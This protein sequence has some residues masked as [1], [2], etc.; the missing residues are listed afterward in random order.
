MEW[1]HFFQSHI[2]DRGRQYFKQGLVKDLHEDEKH[3]RAIVWGSEEYHVTIDLEKKEILR[4]N[5][6]CPY[7]DEGKYCKHMA[8]VLFH[9]EDESTKDLVEKMDERAIRDFLAANLERDENLLNRFRR[10]V[11]GTIPPDMNQCKIKID[12]VFESHAGRNDFINYYNANSFVSEL[13]DIID[14]DVGSLLMNSKYEEAFAVTHYIFVETANQDMDDSDGGKMIL[15]D[16]CLEIWRE[17]LGRC[18]MEVKRNLFHWFIDHLDGTVIDY[19]ESYIEGILFEDFKEDEFLDY[20]RKLAERKVNIYRNEKDSWR[21]SYYAGKWALMNIEVMRDQKLPKNTIDQYCKE[22]LEF[23]EVRKYYIERLIT[24]SQWDSAIHVLEEGKVVDKNRP[25]L[26]TDYSL[27]LRKLYQRIGNADAYETELMSFILEY[28]PGDATAF[29]ELKS[30]YRKEAWLEKR[31]TIFRDLPRHAGI[32][33]LYEIEKLYDRLLNVVI[34]STGLYKLTEYEKCLKPLYPRELLTKYR[35]EVISKASYTSD[36]KQYKEL[37]DV[38]RRMTNY[39]EGSECVRK[40]VAG[41]Q[42]TY[43]NRPAMMDELGKL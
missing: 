23:S 37:V 22:N 11:F 2:F 24:K 42:I 10:E 36:R 9:L 18:E 19:M 20:K 14:E 32:D 31:E 40:I 17:I 26:V 43:K 41:W 35:A 25:G 5:C 39:P 28:H 4:M 27:Q 1:K 8:A 13:E 3:I 33:K 16:R 7:A 21:R 30:L 12:E 15:G 38:L 6:D 34:E 29:K